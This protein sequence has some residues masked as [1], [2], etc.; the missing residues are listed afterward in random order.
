MSTFRQAHAVYYNVYYIRAARLAIY[1]I[2]TTRLTIYNIR[3]THFV[4][5]AV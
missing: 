2:Y 4:S 3:T 1:N 5:F